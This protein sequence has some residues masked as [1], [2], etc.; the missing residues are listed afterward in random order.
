MKRIIVVILG[1]LIVHSSSIKEHEIDN[2]LDHKIMERFSK[3]NPELWESFE[4]E[5]FDRLDEMGLLIDQND[6]IEAIQ[7]LNIKLLAEGYPREFYVDTNI[8]ATTKLLSDLKKIGYLKSD[9]SA[10]KFIFGMLDPIVQ[11]FENE[12]S[13]ELDSNNYFKTYTSYNPDSIQISYDLEILGLEKNRNLEKLWN[14]NGTRKMLILF[15]M[16]RMINIDWVK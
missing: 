2:T 8:D 4:N 6:T 3:Y 1:L 16:S 11:N 13:V 7:K 5:F 12:N 14:K 15:Y 10:H 9:E